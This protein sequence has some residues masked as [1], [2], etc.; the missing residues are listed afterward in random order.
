MNCSIDYYCV[1]KW[2]FVMNFPYIFYFFLFNYQKLILLK[3]S[4]MMKI[5]YYYYHHHHYRTVCVCVLNGS[6]YRPCFQWYSEC[7]ETKK[8]K[9][10]F[11][12]FHHHQHCCCCLMT[13]MLQNFFF[14]LVRSFIDVIWDGHILIQLCLFGT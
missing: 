4:M 8:K 1:T 7:K 11:L 2:V 12:K 14:S 9:F 5:F 13:M 10:F 3:D 6:N